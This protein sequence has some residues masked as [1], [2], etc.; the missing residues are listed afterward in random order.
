MHQRH[1]A[2]DTVLGEV[3]LAAFDE[4]IV[5]LYFRRHLFRPAD[6]TLGPRVAVTDDDLLSGAA[7]QVQQYLT[8]ERDAFDLPT[9]TFGDP[10]QECVWAMLR[11]I[12]RGQTLTYGGLAKRI[13]DRALAQAVGKAVG[14]NPL[15]II[16]PCHR[17]IGANGHLIGYAGGLARKQYLLDLD[18]TV[19]AK[20]TRRP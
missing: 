16:V 6:A 2:T 11:T 4:A 5:G 13:G 9:A 8:G 7:N 12:P 3:T 10:F 15:C 17:V 19:H 1:T 14:Q 20:T 18:K